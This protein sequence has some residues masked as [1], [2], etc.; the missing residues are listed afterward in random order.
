MAPKLVDFNGQGVDKSQW[1]EWR[2]KA[3]SSADGKQLFGLGTDMGGLGLCYR[4]DMFAKAGLPTKRE[5]VSKLIDSW[6][7]YFTTG[8]QFLT[9]Y[10]DKTVKRITR[11]CSPA[12]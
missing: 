4:S 6:D 3:A 8:A 2:W 11:S 10:P 5:D 12:R 9:K 1:S 7:D